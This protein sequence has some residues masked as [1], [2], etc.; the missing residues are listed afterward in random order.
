MQETID[1]C[2][3]YPY[4]H[5]S[6]V[7]YIYIFQFFNLNILKFFLQCCIGFCQTI[8][9]ISLNYTYIP[10]L[11]HIPSPVPDWDPCATLQL[12][13]SYQQIYTTRCKM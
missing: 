10:F 4:T 9:Q 1:L 7:M 6:I 2:Y 8:M 11:L 3:K 12:L 5:H 13:A